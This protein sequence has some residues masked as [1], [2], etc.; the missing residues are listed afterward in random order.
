RGIEVGLRTR[1]RDYWSFSINYAYSRAMANAARPERQNERLVE[2]ISESF[3]EIISEIDQPHNFRGTLTFRVGNESPFEGVLG[4]ITRNAG[5]S[6]T[7]SASSGLPYTPQDDNTGL[8]LQNPQRREINSGRGPATITVNLQANKGFRAGALT[9]DLFLRVNN[10]FDRLNC[11]QVSPQ[12]GECTEGAFDFLNR[13]VGNSANSATSL[14]RPQ[15]IGPRRSIS[16]GVRV[17]F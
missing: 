8:G 15:R 12:S 14:D 4:S 11:I 7:V 10:L 13:R 17:R 3:R 1:V 16:A 6:T 5:I 2:G 9:Y